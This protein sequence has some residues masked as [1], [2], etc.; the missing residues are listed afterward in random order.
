[1]N[2]KARYFKIGLFVIGAVSLA[3]IAIVILGAGKWFQA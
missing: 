3:V 1:V 2:Q